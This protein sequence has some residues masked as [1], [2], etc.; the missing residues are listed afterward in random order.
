MKKTILMTMM[1]AAGTLQLGAETPAKKTPPAA[2]PSAKA[3]ELPADAKASG[4]NQWTHTDEKGQEWIYKRTPFGLTRLPKP[5]SALANAQ[6]QN[7]MPSRMHEGITVREEGELVHFAR[8]GPFGPMKWTKRRD[9]LSEVER[10]AVEMSRRA[11]AAKAATAS[12][13]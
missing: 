13:Q 10:T 8:V 4:T 6:G 12:K 5:G 2:A 9:E 3:L 1:L 7:A 11:P